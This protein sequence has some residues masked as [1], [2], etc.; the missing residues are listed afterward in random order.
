MK[1]TS[2]RTYS[3]EDEVVIRE[4]FLSG[5]KGTDIAT[6]LGRQVGAVESKIKHMKRNGL[7]KIAESPMPKLNEALKTSGDA[8][9]LADVE[10]PF[11]HSDFINRVLDL[12]Y[13]WKIDTLHL[14]GDIL[15][16]ERLS[17]WGA[18]WIP[19]ASGE[20][21]AR[22]EDFIMQLPGKYKNSGIEMIEGMSREQPDEMKHARK[23]MN[24]FDHFKEIVCAI[25]NHDDRY[26]RAL[27]VATSPRELLVQLGKDEK[28][29]W[30]IASYYYSFVETE[31]GMYRI[32]HPRAAGRTAAQDLAVQYHCHVIMGHSHR[33]AV[34]RDPSGDFWAIQTG[35]CVDEERLAY[36]QQ[37]SAKRD[38][39]ALGATIIR[40]G[41]PFV[42]CEAS[43]FEVMKKW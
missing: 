7:L 10:A 5:Q 19:E 1:K 33:W 42:L 15:H 2:Q 12:A 39:H 30:K 41:Y 4:M 25:G 37:R 14:A 20:A 29:N 31:K 40:G 32:E 43:P 34:N 27:N 23:V 22:L 24:S 6:R 3:A 18:E 21:F 16:N 35:H 8:V 38:A 9:I 28:E 13:A 11:Q 26:L 17:A 36:V